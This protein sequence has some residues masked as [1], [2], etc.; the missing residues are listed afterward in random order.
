[1][2]SNDIRAGIKAVLDSF[3]GT[4]KPLVDVFTVH[5][6][7]FSGYPS[8]TFEPGRID[9]ESLTTEENKDQYEWIIVVHQEIEKVGADTAIGILND[10]VDTL[11]AAFSKSTFLNGTVDWVNTVSSEPAGYDEGVGKVMYRM[12]KLVCN[13]SVYIN[14]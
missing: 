6:T 13:K 5:R 4:G 14:L 8:V 11:R 1:M 3:K 7:D 10:V 2:I 12:I 9:S